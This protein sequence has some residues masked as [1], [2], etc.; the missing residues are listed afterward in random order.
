[1]VK[2][3]KMR[4]RILI[5]FLT[6]WTK[7]WKQKNR[8]DMMQQTQQNTVEREKW[9]SRHV[10]GYEDGVRYGGI[11]CQCFLQLSASAAAVPQ[12]QA[13]CAGRVVALCR[14]ICPRVSRAAR[15][16]A[17]FLFAFDC[18]NSHELLAFLDKRRVCVGGGGGGARCRGWGGGGRYP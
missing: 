16:A 12:F 15:A 18:H 13:L 10:R 4:C 3:W 2:W 11:F 8:T 1:M 17:R 7:K 5:C 6:P 9:R 14:A